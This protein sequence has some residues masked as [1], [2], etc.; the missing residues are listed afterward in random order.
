MKYKRNEW[1]KEKR[2]RAGLTQE[3]LADKVNAIAGTKLRSITV[4]RWERGEKR[5]RLSWMKYLAQVLNVDILE[6]IDHLYLRV[7]LED[8]SEEAEEVEAEAQNSLFGG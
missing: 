1:L 6:A 4:S 7:D 2:I 5:P 3:E 8:D